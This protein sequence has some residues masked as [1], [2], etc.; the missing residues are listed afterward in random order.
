MR[1]TPAGPAISGT[2]YQLPPPTP[3]EDSAMATTTR[4]G[5]RYPVL[6]DA[7]NGPQQLRNLAEDVAGWLSRAFPCLSTA[8]P[9]GVGSGFLIHETDT[10]RVQLWT[11]TAWERVALLSDVPAGGGGGAPTGAAGYAATV[12]QMAADETD[13]VVAFGTVLANDPLVTRSG[14]GA[15]HKFVLNSSGIWMITA[16][17][18]WAQANDGGRTFELRAGSTV[19]AKVGASSGENTPWTANLAIVRRLASGTEVHVWGRQDS[20]GSLAIEHGNGNYCHIDLA[21]V[22]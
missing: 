3:P 18:R 22:G 8:R 7:Q 14:Q 9:A 15:G 10:N 1:W 20:G 6:T 13:V 11:G 5:L 2:T 19:L 17:V 16:T 4:N 12:T 21:L